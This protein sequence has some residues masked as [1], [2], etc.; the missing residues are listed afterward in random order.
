MWQA[1]I[2][3]SDARTRPHTPSSTLSLAGA[4]QG[5]QAPAGGA[6]EDEDL[7]RTVISA[8]HAAGPDPEYQQ[9]AALEAENDSRGGNRLEEAPAAR[10][11]QAGASAAISVAQGSSMSPGAPS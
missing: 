11:P 4:L 9:E 10:K 1:S 8:P 5:S 3:P 2:G 7:G 6:D